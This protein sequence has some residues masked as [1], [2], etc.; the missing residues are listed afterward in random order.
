MPVVGRAYRKDPSLQHLPYLLG[1]QGGISHSH[2]R[3]KAGKLGKCLGWLLFA[4]RSAPGVAPI[5]NDKKSTCLPVGMEES[6]I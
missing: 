3:G 2:K 6:R 5:D 4:E 1:A